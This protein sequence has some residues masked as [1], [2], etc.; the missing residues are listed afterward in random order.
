VVGRRWD[1]V[2]ID[3]HFDKAANAGLPVTSA[4]A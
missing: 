3:D 2:A 1:V 4:G